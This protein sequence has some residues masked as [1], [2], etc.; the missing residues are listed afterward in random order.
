LASQSEEQK[1]KEKAAQRKGEP[2]EKHQV[3]K[4]KKSRE[5]VGEQRARDVA[6]K[7]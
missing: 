5:E 6:K 2:V 7:A 3:G 1:E 4:S